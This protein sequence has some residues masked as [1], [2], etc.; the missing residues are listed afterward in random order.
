MQYVVI[1][2]IK[3]YSNYIVKVGVNNETI[4]IFVRIKTTILYI[5]KKKKGVYKY[6]IF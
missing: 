4:R 3:G 6:G 2:A 1:T 5:N